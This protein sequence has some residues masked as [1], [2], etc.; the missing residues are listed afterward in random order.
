[1]DISFSPL[2]TFRRALQYWWLVFLLMLLGGLI[3]WTTHLLKPPVYEASA[4]IS[5]AIDYGQ[6][7]QLT[8]VEEDQML[9]LAGDVIASP[10]VINRVIDKAQQEGLKIDPAVLKKSI[11]PERQDYKWIMHVRLSD[12]QAAARI[13]G[14]W[15]EEAYGVLSDALN[16][17]TN[18]SKVQKY[19]DGLVSC[20]QQTVVTQPD[21]ALCDLDFT[22]IQQNLT[23]AGE[24]LHQEQLASLGILPALRFAEPAIPEV[25][26]NAIQNG[27][28]QLVFAGAIIGFLAGILCVYLDIPA[29][30]LR[31]RAG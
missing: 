8:D 5:F 22:K 16:H 24:Q 6:T 12:P 11:F 31:R 4:V 17:A 19:M 29:Y 28:S 10:L 3:G 14:L 1:M 23:T 27:R 2:E 26:T 15:A 25:P 21:Q 13:S 30:L 18:A 9:G 20:L 7:G